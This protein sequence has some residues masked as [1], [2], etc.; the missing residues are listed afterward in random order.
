VLAH[1]L[2]LSY[3]KRSLRWRRALIRCR[4]CAGTGFGA[5]GQ[6]SGGGFTPNPQQQ[7]PLQ[8]QPGMTPASAAGS[9]DASICGQCLVPPGAPSGAYVCCCD[10][11][12]K[13][14]NAAADPKG[15]C[16]KNFAQVCPGQ[17]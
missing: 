9:C 1:K 3:S 8:Q 2:H 12:C 11:A 4:A 5:G 14:N 10:R 7:L 16:C 13:T 17:Q 6:I 15:S